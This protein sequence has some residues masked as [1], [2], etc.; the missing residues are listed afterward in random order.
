MPQ[1]ENVAAD[2]FCSGQALP[3]FLTSMIYIYILEFNLFKWHL[4][5]F[6]E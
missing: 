4:K 5:G 1:K 6:K 3:I 2:P